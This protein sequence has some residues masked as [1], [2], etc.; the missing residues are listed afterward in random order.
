MT[1]VKLAAK[2]PKGGGNGL[3]ALAEKL[4]SDLHEIRVAI[5][6]FDCSKVTHDHDSG[7]D[8]PT[9]RIRRI[10]PIDGKAHA[11]IMRSALAAAW[12]ER[13]GEDTLPFDLDIDIDAA[14]GGRTTLR[15]VD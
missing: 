3:A 2:L 13:T 11:G 5:V 6:L 9:A 10:E 15:A 8:I 4:A 14:L 7:E 1:A 12:A